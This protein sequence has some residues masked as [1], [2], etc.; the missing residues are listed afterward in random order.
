MSHDH[1]DDPDAGVPGVAPWDSAAYAPA[2]EPAFRREQRRTVTQLRDLLRR[3]PARPNEEAA[4]AGRPRLVAMDGRSASGKSS[5]ARLLAEGQSGWAVV[6]TDDIA[7]WHS[8]FDWPHLLIDRVIK[9]LLAD[10]EVSYTPPAWTERGRLGA[11]NVP[12]G[13]HTVVIEGVGAA[14]RELQPFLNR[15]VWV[16]TPWP[17]VLRREHL[18]LAAGEVSRELQR[19]WMSAELKF[20]EQQRPWERASLVISGS[21]H[22]PPY[23]WQLTTQPE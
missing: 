22:G 12:A 5:L 10:G 1:V 19:D 18:R 23:V 13:V 21:E 8:Y 14:R 9:P 17:E 2:F 6:H 3:P 20:V 11:I 4:A 7:W 15:S 16:H